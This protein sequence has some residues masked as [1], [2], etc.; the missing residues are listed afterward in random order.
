VTSTSGT[1][2]TKVTTATKLWTQIRKNVGHDLG[3]LI[4]ERRDDEGMRCWWPGVLPRLVF[5]TIAVFKGIGAY[6]KGDSEQ[7]K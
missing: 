4:G 3:A 7:K 2:E 1:V 6:N 5:S